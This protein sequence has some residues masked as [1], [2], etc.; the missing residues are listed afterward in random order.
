VVGGALS[1]T[2]PLRAHVP[3][4]GGYLVGRGVGRGIIHAGLA[5][6]HT[7][8]RTGLLLFAAGLFLDAARIVDAVDA[9]SGAQFYLDGGGGLRIGL[10]E[11]QLG[12]LRI[13]LAKGLV[14]DRPFALTVGVHQGWPL[15]QGGY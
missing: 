15:F 14:A 3:T 6:D 11:G 4:D 13:D 1:W 5:G 9:A 10:A 2:I 12:V 7:L 8:Y